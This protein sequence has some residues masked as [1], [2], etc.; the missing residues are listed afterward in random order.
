M[1]PFSP[2][3]FPVAGATLAVGLAGAVIAAHQSAEAASAA[4]HAHALDVV[5]RWQT[6][7]RR[8]GAQLA[9]ERAR[10]DELARDLGDAL[11]VIEDLE[12]QLA[13]ARAA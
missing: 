13:A 10:A 4:T 12:R 5:R 3:P 6:H 2:P 11:A 1:N 9:A 7:A 8:L